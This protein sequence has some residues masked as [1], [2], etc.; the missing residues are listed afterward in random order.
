MKQAILILLSVLLLAVVIASA[1]VNFNPPASITT[2]P[3]VV[4]QGQESFYRHLELGVLYEQLGLLQAGHSQYEEASLSEQ[5]E[6]AVAAREGLSRLTVYEHNAWTRVQSG[7][8]DSMIELAQRALQVLA[9]GAAILLLVTIVLRI[10]R[11]SGYMLL[12]F[13][14]YSKDKLGAGLHNLV[15][16]TLT[17]TWRAYEQWSHEVLYSSDRLDVPMFSVLSDDAKAME[18]ALAS[19]DVAGGDGGSTVWTKIVRAWQQWLSSR[20]HVILG[21]LHQHGETLR[22]VVEVRKTRTNEVVST[23]QL[24]PP[25]TTQLSE[26]AGYLAQEFAFRLMMTFG[27]ELNARSWR[28]LQ[29]FSYG[30]IETERARTSGVES[31]QLQRVADA[32]TQ[33][34][35]LDP[36]YAAA[37]FL[38]GLVCGRLGKYPDARTEFREVIELGEDLT[39]AATYNLAIAF[40]QEFEGWANDKAISH[41]S[42]VEERLK[43][44]KGAE[45]DQLLTALCH[46]GLA[47]AHAQRVKPCTEIA[48]ALGQGPS[49]FELVQGHCNAALRFAPDCKPVQAA[50]HNALGVAYWKVKEFETAV[51]ELKTA[52]RMSP[53][54]PVPYVYLARM[55]VDKDPGEPEEAIEWLER[56]VRWHPDYEYAHFWLGKLYAQQGAT[57]TAKDHY[58]RAT[59][60]SDARNSLGE[61]LA[62]EGDYSGALEQF[63]QATLLNRRNARA[64]SNLAWWTMEAGADDEATLRAAAGWA[65]RALE[66]NR[67]TTF[68]WLNRDSLGWILLHLGQTKEAESELAQSIKLRSDRIQNRYHLAVLHRRGGEI[69]KSKQ[70]LVEAFKISEKGLWREKAEAMMKE[71]RDTKMP[72]NSGVTS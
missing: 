25:S 66:L 21:S 59:G 70:A 61:L 58:G 50:T 49:S 57:E 29:L 10:P 34:L 38:L 35:V 23:W 69:G 26:Q 56:A 65:R 51:E 5:P 2:P 20:D 42:D 9:I 43:Q 18:Y 32:L 36:G 6:I 63:R 41:F 67:G 62:R 52:I 8:R 46:C 53:D 72:E 64:W 11:K 27:L 71:L 16:A 44:G 39:T 45:S 47:N 3:I 17:E 24:L 14:D 7:L 68:E 28:S 40:Y 22:L 13:E 30:L 54:N 48:E 19:L 33:A 60:I 31:G 1:F 37:H 55:Y 4:A 12:P 15:Y